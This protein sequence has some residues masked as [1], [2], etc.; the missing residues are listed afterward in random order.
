MSLASADPDTGT[1]AVRRDADN[2]RSAS[3]GE[4][5][6]DYGSALAIT[7][8]LA[9]AAFLVAMSAAL[10]AARPQV[11]G[12]GAFTGLIKQQNQDAKTALYAA[13]FIAILPVSLVFGPRIADAIARGP[14]GGA[15]PGLAAGLVATLAALMV[16]LRASRWLPWGDGLWSV[17][18]G[19]LLWSAVA[20]AA[21][22]RA[23]RDGAWEALG[24][25]D[26]ARRPLMVAAGAVVLAAI[27]CLTQRSSLGIARLALAGVAAGAALIAYCRLPIPHLGRGPGR[28]VDVLVG[29]L[30]IFAI[31]DVV[32][33]HSSGALPNVYFEPGVIQF[34][35]DYIL[36]PTNQLLG[37]GAL[38]VGAPVSQ[39]GVGLIDFL[40]GWFH[41]VP[42]G[43]GTFGFLDAALTGLFYVAAYCVLRISGVNR[44]LAAAAVGVGTVVLVYNLHFPVG[45]LPEEG[46]LRFGLPMIVLVAA[47][48]SIRWP[49]RASATQ[50]IALAALAV[51][52]IWA[53]EAFV[54]TALTFTGIVL[55][56]GWL[57]PVGT[58]RAWML[59]RALVGVSACVLAHV[60]FALATLVAVGQLPDWGMYLSYVR[61][62]VS[63][64]QAGSISYGFARWPPGLAVGAA[65]LASAAAAI[66]LAAR[67]PSI[68][69]REPAI[70]V[71]LS[72]STAYEIAILSY[73]DNRS[74]TYL[75]PY[76][77]LPLLVA[78]VLWLALL[79][80]VPDATSR[81]A[82]R[83]GVAFVLALAALLV[84]VAWPTVGS[85]FSRTA[86]AHA[87]PGGGLG[88][89]L[90]R[91]WHPPPIDPR[92][93]VGQRLLDRY[94]PGRRA[95]ILLPTVPDLG[96]EIL[97]RSRRSNSMFIGDPKADSL[98][99][100][101][102]MEK[103]KRSV[104]ELRGGDR[105]LINDQT[106]TVAAALRAD[107]SIDVV[108]HPI[109]NGTGQT[110][111][112][113]REIGRRF[114]LAPIYRDP[115]GLIIAELAPRS[116]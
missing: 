102:W 80:R 75:L 49:R 22:A 95:L 91:L 103:L 108:N 104:A 52:A 105:L 34:Q 109:A 106:L 61:S 87:Y 29:A 112:L 98:V 113:V 77:A 46:P 15:L 51:S 82:R 4:L 59:R 2:S 96:T 14:N 40:A 9:V 99:P 8:T 48:A 39:Y 76:V 73:I 83:G 93:P 43:Y 35:H 58:R 21:I 56:H 89:A 71:A 42:I 115:D 18:A 66:L 78:G 60:I 31:T 37:G 114:R 107:P 30:L 67:K 13:S 74:S 33:F 72:G 84:A 26:R 88:A 28:L 20:A 81:L 27:V 55:A 41:L 24:R 86:L 110:E 70:L 3:S 65:A 68:A 64:N 111:W 36:G 92:A 44:L 47:V 79:L 85:R 25:L 6:A 100:S 62:V 5:A 53:L 32:V 11:Q 116:G 101:V 10:L 94:I 12:L 19:T 97:I 1:A 57:Q 63:G 45:E 69:R 54:Y 23:A 90:H 38:L 17:L 16:L 50:A 7:V